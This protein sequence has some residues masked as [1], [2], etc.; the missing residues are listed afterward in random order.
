MCY[1]TCKSGYSGVGPVCWQNCPPG[2]TDTGAD[3]LKPASY[4]RGAGYALWHKS[5]CESE[6][7]QG[8]EKNGLLYYPKCKEGFH[9]VGCCICS[10]DCSDGMT[11]IEVSCQKQSYGRGAGV[12]LICGSGKEEDAALCYDSCKTGYDGIGPVCWDSCP[13]GKYQCGALCLPTKDDCTKDMLKLGLDVLNAVV[14]AATADEEADVIDVLETETE[15]ELVG[16]LDYPVCN[17]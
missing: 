6:N 5:E 10:P 3:C 2:F 7:P 9:S 15:T 17:N 8:C 14:T 13:T 11:D 4:G 16:D 12:P 1:P